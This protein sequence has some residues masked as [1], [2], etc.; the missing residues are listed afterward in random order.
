LRLGRDRKT[1]PVCLSQGGLSERHGVSVAL[2]FTDTF[3]IRKT[4]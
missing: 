4:I 2:A 1:K 3:V